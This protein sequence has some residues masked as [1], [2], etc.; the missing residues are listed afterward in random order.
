MEDS[1]EL[2][3]NT[4]GTLPYDTKFQF[5]YLFKENNNTSIDRYM[6]PCMYDSFI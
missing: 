4:N 1:M 5:C 2:P 6:H 3:K